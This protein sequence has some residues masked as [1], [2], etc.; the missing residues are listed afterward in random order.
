MS[1][2]LDKLNQFGSSFEGGAMPQSPAEVR[3]RGDQIR[4]R[5]HALIAGASALAVAAVAVPVIALTSIGGDTNTDRPP[6]TES[7]QTPTDPVTPGASLTEANLVTADEL[8]APSG[9]AV[10]EVD[11]VE[12][13]RDVTATIC[14]QESFLNMDAEGVLVRRF[15]LGMSAENGGDGDA[16]TY[17]AETIAE[18]PDEATAGAAFEAVTQWVS[19]CAPEGADPIEPTGWEGWEGDTAD[20]SGAVE[21]LEYGPATAAPGSQYDVSGRDDLQWRNHTGIVL[22]GDRLAVWSYLTLTSDY[23][24]SGPLSPGAVMPLM[25]DKLEGV[26]GGNQGT[27]DSGIGA[28][29]LL[30]DDDA[31]YPNGGGDWDGGVTSQG[32]QATSS[33]CQ[34]TSFAD[35]GATDV[36][37]RDFTFY[38]DGVP[39]TDG[40]GFLNE[41]IT[42]YADA[43]AAAAAYDQI[44]GWFEECAPANPSDWGPG[45]WNQIEAAGAESAEQM[46]VF[47]EPVDEDL[48]QD[49]SYILDT[50]LVRTGNRVA[51]LTQQG[52]GM[53]YNF[54]TTPVQQMLPVAA[55][56][57]ANGGGVE[58]DETDEGDTATSTEISD[59]IT[60]DVD[61]AA[62]GGE[63]SGPERP[64]APVQNGLVLC[65]QAPSWPPTGVDGAEIVDELTAGATGETWTESRDLVTLPTVNDAVYAMAQ[66]GHVLNACPGEGTSV[67]T[68][69]DALTGYETTTF[70]WSY[71]NS[72]GVTVLQFTRVGNA[73]LR[74]DS[75]DSE[76]ELADA[77]PMIEATIDTSM[78]IAAEMKCEFSA[79]GC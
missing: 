31:V 67:Y 39:T 54:T 7:S 76:T 22:S 15:G 58:I 41:T 43:E 40:S 37:Q 69:Q 60:L 79:E 53:D 21:L 17:I 12:N 71:D 33:P 48:P 73:I 3:R 61:L 57:L 11:T 5:T 10:T 56:R 34:P 45:A 78:A 64:D 70:T 27:P 63:V 52:L 6:V 18:F 49:F 74:V 2:P 32:E 42:E 14:Q 8:E 51:L 20:R 77:D 13:D 55:D 29:N 30:T 25:A 72:P 62:R 9:M 28:A 19:A 23:D 4:R 68:V 38:S 35:L 47:Y 44:L 16:D 24:S 50:G 65:D 26:E 46:V 66:L 59:D 36:W 75:S 1:D